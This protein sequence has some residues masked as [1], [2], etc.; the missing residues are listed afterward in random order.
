M[1]CFPE[2]ALLKKG[3]ENK[4]GRK[5]RKEGGRAGRKEEN[6]MVSS[7]GTSS[8]LVVLVISTKIY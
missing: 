4:E 5:A 8:M 2:L 1:H 6:F 7:L 3:K